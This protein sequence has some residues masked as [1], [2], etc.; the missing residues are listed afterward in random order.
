MTD[1]IKKEAYKG[2]QILVVD[3]SHLSAREVS[4]LID[5]AKSMIVSSKQKNIL[6]LE[7]VTGIGISTN[8]VES[9]KT[10][11]NEIRP[12]VDRYAVV[13]VQGMS[14]IVA[15]TLRLLKII[16]F[17]LFSHENEAK[18]YLIS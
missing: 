10:Y 9:L 6:L 16:P 2:K 1:R 3:Y 7:Y 13:G 14:K 5:N 12:Y 8:M 17:E 18:E 11:T 15:S 4:E